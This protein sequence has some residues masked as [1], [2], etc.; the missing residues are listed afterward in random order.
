MQPPVRPERNRHRGTDG[1]RDE[2]RRGCAGRG[3]R[4]RVLCGHQCLPHPFVPSTM[5]TATPTPSMYTVAEPGSTGGT[6]T[7]SP[8]S[9]PRPTCS[10]STTIH[11]PTNSALRTFAVARYRPDG[12]RTVAAEKS[13][14][15]PPT[16]TV[17]A[18]V[19]SS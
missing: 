11:P 6:A 19:S 16:V 15:R 8:S 12:G 1:D 5:C 9:T 7:T 17:P 18:A 2:Q 4:R 10:P 3:T 14:D 13:Q